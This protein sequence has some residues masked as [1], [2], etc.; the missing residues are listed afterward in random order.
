[1]TSIET[2]AFVLGVI[3]V[4]LV[5][6]RS[7]WNYPFALAMVALYAIV[8]RDA[9]LYS[10]MLLQGFFFVVNLYGWA[11]WR[12]EA[13]AHG[14]VTVGTM[15]PAARWRWAAGCLVATLAWG[16][17]MHRFTDAAYPW[18]DAGI[19]IVS[20]AAQWLLAQRRIENWVLWIAVDI[21]SIAL[22]AAKGLRLTTALYVVFLAL[23]VWGLVDWTR[24]RR[25][26][27]ALAPA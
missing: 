15:T 7:V 26:D 18:W 1:M 23:A 4:T 8:F 10:D 27:G 20:I 25:Q 19:A 9:R 16:A 14:S 5:V 21:A 13:A 24:A 11:A 17:L 12:A 22:Y 2:I 3:N 6:R